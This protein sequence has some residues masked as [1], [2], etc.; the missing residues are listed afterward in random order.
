LCKRDKQTLG[1][2]THLSALSQGLG[3]QGSLLEQLPNSISVAGSSAHLAKQ[4]D[5]KVKPNLPQT[6]T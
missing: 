1:L 2:R 3:S 5:A 4:A 6:G